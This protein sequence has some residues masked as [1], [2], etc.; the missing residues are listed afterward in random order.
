MEER[1]QNLQ[2]A[3]VP[4]LEPVPPGLLSGEH[5]DGSHEEIYYALVGLLLTAKLTGYS[6]LAVDAATK[7]KAATRTETK[8]ALGSSRRVLVDIV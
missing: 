7:G 4:E 3:F 8:K 6:P 5:N 1:G 2:E